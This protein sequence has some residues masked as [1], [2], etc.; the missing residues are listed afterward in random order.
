[1][2]DENANTN[3]NHSHLDSQSEQG[4][5]EPFSPSVDIDHT[6]SNFLE[7]VPTPNNF[8]NPDGSINYFLDIEGK[9]KGKPGRP[10]GSPNKKTEVAPYYRRNRSVEDEDLLKDIFNLVF[11]S[12]LDKEA[13]VI[14][15]LRIPRYCWV[16][17]INKPNSKI[18]ETIVDAVDA[19]EVDMLTR[20]GEAI[21][22]TGK[23]A[24][25]FLSDEVKRIRRKHGES[26]FV[27]KA[28]PSVYESMSVEDLEKLALEHVK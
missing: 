23:Y 11:K 21:D 27:I 12:G 14:A 20:Y 10:K 16:N 4:G 7:T 13:F 5:G 26:D 8:V 18:R 15:A 22:G 28:A 2:Q 3:D 9:P 19:Y 17:M 1:M 6:P 25:Q 24:M